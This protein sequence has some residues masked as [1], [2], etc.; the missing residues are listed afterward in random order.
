[1]EEGAPEC[2][3][4]RVPQS[5]LLQTHILHVCAEGLVCTASTCPRFLSFSIASCI[6]RCEIKEQGGGRE[7]EGHTK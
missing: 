5:W 2:D 6:L 3:D 1:M 4:E 7:R